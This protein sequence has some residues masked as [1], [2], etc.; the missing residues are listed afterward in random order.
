MKALRQALKIP[1]GI[2]IGRRLLAFGAMLIGT[3]TELVLKSR[4]VIPQRLY[5]SGFTFEYPTIRR[6][7]KDLIKP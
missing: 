7:L 6:A 2:P 1:C 4:N 3:E 5:E